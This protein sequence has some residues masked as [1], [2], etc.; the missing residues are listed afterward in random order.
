MSLFDQNT[1]Y[2]CVSPTAT[3]HLGKYIS[4]EPQLEGVYVKI[5]YFTYIFENGAIGTGFEQYVKQLPQIY[6]IPNE[7]ERAFTETNKTVDYAL[8]RKSVPPKDLG[9]FIGCE[10]EWDDNWSYRDGPSRTTYYIFE[11]SRLTPN[12]LQFVKNAKQ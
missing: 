6:D 5:G 7:P 1:E 9:K 10:T 3:K 8:Y 4:R 2:E 11:K 12:E